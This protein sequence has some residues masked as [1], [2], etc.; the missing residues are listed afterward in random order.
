MSRGNDNWSHRHDEVRGQISK[1]PMPER[2]KVSPLESA[3][4]DLVWAI[5][6]LIDEPMGI[7][8]WFLV[9]DAIAKYK[10]IREDRF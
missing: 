6:A 8:R 9:R 3:G 7:R 5:E 2:P 10:L 4:D 1:R